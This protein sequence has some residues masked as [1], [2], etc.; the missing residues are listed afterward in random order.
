L[1]LSHRQKEIIKSARIGITGSPGTGKKSVGLELARLTGLKFISLNEV[2]IKNRIGRWK[3]GEFLVDISKLR[4]K[5]IET[6]GKIIVGHLLPYVIPASNLDFVAIL[7]CS[8]NVLKKRYSSR[9]YSRSKT[10][11]NLE[12]ELLGIISFK[13]LQAYGRSKVGEFD[14]TRT[15]NPVRTALLI[16]KTML[17]ERSKRYG[18]EKWSTGA[19]KSPNRLL[20]AVRAV[21][22]PRPEGKK[23][24]RL[25]ASKK[26]RTK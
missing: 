11:E 12:A 5:K 14:T 8:P 2:A 17:G 10:E 9:G 16:L 20:A 15:R 4:R 24:T 26:L 13:A 21:E 6:R 18:I 22:S 19:A 3:D 7:R 25:P 23:I 1:Q